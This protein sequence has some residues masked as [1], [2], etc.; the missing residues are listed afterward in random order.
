MNFCKF[1]SVPFLILGFFLD[2]YRLM[3]IFLLLIGQMTIMSAKH[4]MCERYEIENSRQNFNQQEM[5]R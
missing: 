5:I 4:S 1:V 3:D 2:A